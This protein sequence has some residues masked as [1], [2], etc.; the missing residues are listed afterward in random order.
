MLADIFAA[1]VSPNDDEN[2]AAISQLI[3]C[4]G[5]QMVQRLICAMSRIW[6]SRAWPA[7]TPPRVRLR[8]PMRQSTT[9]LRRKTP[10]ATGHGIR[11]SGGG[12][13][14]GSQC[15]TQ[16]AHG[17]DS[18]GSYSFASQYHTRHMFVGY[19]FDSDASDGRVQS[20]DA[21][22]E[23]PLPATAARNH[24]PSAANTK[25]DTR[26]MNRPR[27]TWT[28]TRCDRA[29]CTSRSSSHRGTSC[30]SRSPSTA[31]SGS[32]TRASRTATCLRPS[33]AGTPA[34]CASGPRGR[35]RI[36][37]V[38]LPRTPVYNILDMAVDYKARPRSLVV[39]DAVWLS[40]KDV[41]NMK[42]VEHVTNLCKVNRGW[43]IRQDGGWFSPPL[44]WGD[45]CWIDAGVQGCRGAGT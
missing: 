5:P 15:Q 25:R 28:P 27:R 8:T 42:L 2:L 44:V 20:R 9:T 45:W 33:S 34:G 26:T 12:Y 36:G 39:L 19:A 43:N 13:P 30:T 10:Q 32:A 14:C 21:L 40:V 23:H 11:S 29:S 3:P 35:C 24:Q 6:K 37:C 18:I 31:T 17:V 7:G 16:R 1:M 41:Q 4:L 22:D 38:N